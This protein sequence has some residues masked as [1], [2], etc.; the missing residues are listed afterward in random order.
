[1]PIRGLTDR[2][3]VRPRL[4]PIGQIR[5]GIKDENGKMHD[6]DYFRF[7]AK[8]PAQKAVQTAFETA[9]GKEPRL[10]RVVTPYP[11]VEEN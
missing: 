6:L 8:G 10:I 1:M 3:S 7:V 9:Y 5:K 2:E 11:T 4:T